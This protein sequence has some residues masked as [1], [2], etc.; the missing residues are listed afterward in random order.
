MSQYFRNHRL[1][2]IS[3]SSDHQ[4][5]KL[6][7]KYYSF[8]N[9]IHAFQLQIIIFL[10]NNLVTIKENIKSFPALQPSRHHCHTNENMSRGQFQALSCCSHLW[11]LDF[12]KER[13][14]CNAQRGS[15]LSGIIMIYWRVS[16][17]CYKHYLLLAS[18]PMGLSTSAR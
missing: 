2:S 17:L 16:L 1:L 9:K 5:K 4:H 11:Y 13:M 15:I 3:L 7:E 6:Y 10:L 12:C 14:C 18:T 8:L